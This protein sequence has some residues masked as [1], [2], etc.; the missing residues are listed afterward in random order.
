MEF[1]TQLLA[2]GGPI[3]LGIVVIF[4][5]MLLALK[6]L[7]E[8]SKDEKKARIESEAKHA[9]RYENVVKQM[10]E[11]VNTNTQT[12]TAHT[13]VARELKDSMRELRLTINQRDREDLSKTEG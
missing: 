2:A 4:L 10:F 9:D 13:E 8:N 3:T 7:W 11:V 12:L 1:L 5:L 6:I